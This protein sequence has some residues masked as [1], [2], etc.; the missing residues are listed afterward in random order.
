M[1]ILNSRSRV[2]K[3]PFLSYF[4]QKRN[5]GEPGHTSIWA[6][7]VTS[8][9]ISSD[10][11]FFFNSEMW[12]QHHCMMFFACSHCVD[13]ETCHFF[14]KVFSCG[15]VSKTLKQPMRRQFKKIIKIILPS[16]YILESDGLSSAGKWVDIDSQFLN[17]LFRV[18]VGW[19]ECF[20][21]CTKTQQSVWRLALPSHTDGDGKIQA[22]KQKKFCTVFCSCANSCRK[23]IKEQNKTKT[24]LWLLQRLH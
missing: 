8:N 17:N 14:C 24:Q 10:Y 7:T 15:V 22:D 20:Q 11:G 6:G 5:W 3:F 1:S 18:L 16:N 19:N 2:S 23:D 4:A 13:V 21:L 12:G 9:G